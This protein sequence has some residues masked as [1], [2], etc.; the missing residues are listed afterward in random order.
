M[1]GNR[2]AFATEEF[3]TRVARVQSEMSVRGIDIL[4]L[5]APENIYYLTGHQTS[6]YFAYQT[7]VLAQSGDPQLLLRLLEKGNVD[8][9][10]WLPDAFTWKEGDDL[11]EKTLDLVRRFGIAGK[12]VGL[13]KKC[14]FLT[15]AI[16]D[17]L[18]NGLSDATIVDAS[19]LVDRV[20]VIKSAAEIGYIRRAAQIAEIE[21]QVAFATICDGATEAQVAAAVFAAGVNAGCEYTGLPH[22]IMSGYRYNVCH[23]NWSPKIIQR[24]ELV[25]FELYGCLER[26]HATQMRTVAIGHASDEVRRA[27]DIVVAA[28][29][30]GIA[31]MKPGAS[32]REVDALVRKPIRK[33]RPEYY[34]RSGYSTG[35]GFPPKTAEW[36][37]LDF[38]EQE[39]WE[40]KEGMAFHMLALACGFGI[41][42]TV[43]V[44]SKGVERLTG[45]NRRE[46]LIK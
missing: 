23:A 39:D 22:H 25:L 30:A 18:T 26:Y 7:L 5:H 4:L 19:L 37:A 43:V 17:A 24:G 2:Q 44:T 10:S 41:S 8:E 40:L 12:R 34:N 36:E 14:W 42:E 20:R 28:Q 46:L 11:V 29:D 9:Y 6:G 3:K 45:S 1:T 21:Q 13:E 32:A 15:S 35:I 31:A 38:N 33:I 16:A 27:A